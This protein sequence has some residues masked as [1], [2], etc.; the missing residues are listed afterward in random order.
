MNLTTLLILVAVIGVIFGQL[1]LKSGMSNIG[2]I[3]QGKLK[4]PVPLIC[5]ILTES[6]VILGLCF[7]ISSSILWIYI[8]SFADLSYAFPFLSIAYVGVPTMASLVLHEKIPIKQWLGITLV[9]AGIILVAT[10]GH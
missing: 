4:K 8:L 9:V 2:K 3:D 10:T 1:C 7:Y 6:R 5:S